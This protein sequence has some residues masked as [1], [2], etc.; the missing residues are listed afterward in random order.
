M[1]RDPGLE[2]F[3]Q[4]LLFPFPSEFPLTAEQEVEKV[5]YLTDGFQPV[6]P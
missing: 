2:K 5:E 6:N 4:G 3:S 1:W